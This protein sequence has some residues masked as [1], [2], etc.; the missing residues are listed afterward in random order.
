METI[1]AK[2][3]TRRQFITTLAAGTAGLITSQAI[4][5]LTSDVS[6]SQADALNNYGHKN[7]ITKPFVMYF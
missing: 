5:K 7:S 6:K 4:A 2:G 3:L 1:Q